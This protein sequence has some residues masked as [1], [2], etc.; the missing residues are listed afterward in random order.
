MDDS[1][2][3]PQRPPTPTHTPSIH[4][5]N[6]VERLVEAQ[7]EL[8]KH[9]FDGLAQFVQIFRIPPGQNAN[10]TVTPDLSSFRVKTKLTFLMFTLTA[11]R[12]LADC[13]KIFFGIFMSLG[14]RRPRFALVQQEGQIFELGVCLVFGRVWVTG[15][16]LKPRP[17]M[18]MF[19]FF[20]VPF[21][22]C[23]QI[24]GSLMLELLEW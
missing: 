18:P 8:F 3:P 17:C 23:K 19:F 12:L 2:D 10:D 11:C 15:C 20:K 24:F 21:L 1:L 14:K 6:L 16:F 7:N 22:L 9:L 13:L 5:S 4:C